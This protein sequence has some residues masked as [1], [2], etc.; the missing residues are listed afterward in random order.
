MMMMMM[1]MM[2]MVMVAAMLQVHFC[3][4][5]YIIRQGARGDTFYIIAGG[6][7][8]T[9]TTCTPR[10]HYW[11]SPMIISFFVMVNFSV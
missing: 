11:Y 3:N 2:M 4:G 6:R 8:S 7:V 1:M 10:L 5:E 9:V